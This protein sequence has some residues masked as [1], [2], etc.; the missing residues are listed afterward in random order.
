MHCGPEA[1]TGPRDIVLLQFADTDNILTDNQTL[2]L[3]IERQLPVVA[4]MLD[5]QTYYSNF[6]CGI[7]PQVRLGEASG[8]QVPGRTDPE[9]SRPQPRTFSPS[10]LLSPHS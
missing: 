2:K 9:A 7:T 5:S 3:L 1:E 4:P 10:G 8:A 6:W